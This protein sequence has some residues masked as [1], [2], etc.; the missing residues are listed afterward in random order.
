MQPNAG[1]GGTANKP[2]DH[3]FH[4]PRTPWRP[5]DT[6]EKK[7]VGFQNGPD[8]TAAGQTRSGKLGLGYSTNFGWHLPENFPVAQ[9]SP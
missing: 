8:E 3:S 4:A 9:T 2:L 5:R 6:P 7:E 1:D